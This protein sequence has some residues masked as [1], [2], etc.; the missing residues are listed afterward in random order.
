MLLDTSSLLSGIGCIALNQSKEI[1]AVHFV[2]EPGFGA[3]YT[4][5]MSEES[6]KNTE[7]PVESEKEK[8]RREERERNDAGFKLVEEDNADPDRGPIARLV[9]GVFKAA[10]ADYIKNENRS[11]F[12]DDFEA[13]RQSFLKHFTVTEAQR[14]RLYHIIIGS[15]PNEKANFFDVEGEWSVAEAMRKLAKKYNIDIEKV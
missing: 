10:V 2:L 15:S 3:G 9:R 7:N 4:L 1:G 14:Y 6:P 12:F 13:F 5:V 8:S 11:P